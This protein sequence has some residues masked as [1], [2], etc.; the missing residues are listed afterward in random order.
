MAVGSIEIERKF[1]VEYL[2][3]LTGVRRATIRQGYL[4]VPADSIE[5]RVRQK[6]DAFY[7]TL[8]SD[9]GVVRTERELEITQSQFDTL[10]PATK[11]LRVEKERWSGALRDGLVF[12][13]DIFGGALAPLLLVEVEFSSERTAKAFTAPDWFG[14]DV[15]ENKRYKNK[16]L[17]QSGKP[18]P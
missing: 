9:G 12:E 5:I 7:M 17:A 18:E 11:G 13:L 16:A 2:P 15:T 6:H 3:E 8:K 10:W 1:L 4:T 14:M